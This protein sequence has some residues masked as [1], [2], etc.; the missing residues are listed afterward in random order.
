MN[1]VAVDGGASNN[2]KLSPCSLAE[3][4]PVLRSRQVC[5][6]LPD[7]ARGCKAVSLWLPLRAG[8]V[9]VSLMGFR[10]PPLLACVG[11]PL[12]FYRSPL[13]RVRER[14]GGGGQ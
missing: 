14:G 3:I 13:K 1:A 10:W 11:Y 5:V 9:C 12:V 8:R 2:F 4:D 7:D 6:R